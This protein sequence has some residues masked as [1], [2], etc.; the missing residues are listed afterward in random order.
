MC[1]PGAQAYHPRARAPISLRRS[2]QPD[3][4]PSSLL[5]VMPTRRRAGTPGW[6][7]TGS[8]RDRYGERLRRC[9]AEAEPSGRGMPR[10]LRAM[11]VYA[12]FQRRDI[13]R[14]PLTISDARLSR[15]RSA[16]I[17][18]IV[19]QERQKPRYTQT[20][21]FGYQGD[22]QEENRLSERPWA[23]RTAHATKRQRSAC[24]SDEEEEC[25]TMVSP[26]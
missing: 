10:P 22:W 16:C 25:C 19:S 4:A 17:I 13:A 15:C 7:M 26:E 3:A 18:P 2:M 8:L 20:F 12:A 9:H 21:H 14:D 6:R 5:L 23:D 24:Q 11:T 1:I